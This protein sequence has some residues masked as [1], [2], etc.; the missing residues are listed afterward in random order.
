VE[1]KYYQ[2]LSKTHSQCQAFSSIHLQQIEHAIF[3]TIFENI[4]DVP[5]FEKAISESMPNEKMI[6]DLERK[7]KSDEK[8]LKRISRELDKLIDLALSGTLTKET[9]RNKEQ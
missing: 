5:N 2:H 1:H 6:N 3:E 9:I 4:C 7:I 8:K